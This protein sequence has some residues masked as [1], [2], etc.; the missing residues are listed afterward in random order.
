MESGENERQ[1]FGEMESYEEM[2]EELYSKLPEKV[3]KKERFEMPRVNAFIEGN[4]TIFKNFL[5]IAQ[6]IRRDVEMFAKYLSRELASPVK[7]D[8]NRLIIQR[9]VNLQLLQ[10]KV[11]L[12]IK[13]YVLCWECGKPDTKIAVIEGVKMLICEACGARRPIR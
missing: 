1:S 7:I 11:E 12:F 5:S 9:R 8:G 13:D 10:R 2:L 6:L 3:K 4:K